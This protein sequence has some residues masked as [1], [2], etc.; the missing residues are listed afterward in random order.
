MLIITASECEKNHVLSDISVIVSLLKVMISA[1]GNPS[2]QDFSMSQDDS[3]F[4]EIKI[5]VEELKLGMYVNRLDKSWGE[6]SFLFQGFLIENEKLL[7]Q[8]RK[9]CRHVYIDTDRQAD[10]S[11]ESLERKSFFSFENLLGKKDESGLIRVQRPQTN[12]LIDIIKHKVPVETI[13]PPK[14]LASFEQEMGNAKLAQIKVRTMLK[15]FNEK[16][17]HGST[18]DMVAAKYAISDCMYSLLRSPDALLLINRLKTKRYT[19]WQHGMN[20]SVLAMSLG[21]YLNID[22]DELITLGLCGMFHDVGELLISKKKLDEAG[23]KK[24][25]LRSHTLLGRDLLLKCMGQMADVA[26][27]VAYCHHEHLDGSGFPRGL[28]AGQISMY[29]QIIGMVDVY[30]TLITDSAD[31]KGMTHYEAMTLLLRQANHSFDET[32]VNAFNK[33]I[34]TYP[35]GAVVEMNT[36][37]LAVVV[38]ENEAQRLRPK[39]MLLTDADKQKCN[40]KVV[41][42][43]ETK[44]SADGKL[45]AIKAIVR[46]DDYGV[47]L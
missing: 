29:A 15:D 6:S 4:N 40:K 46:A 36:G 31:K 42:L 32:L 25:L 16:I 21:R 18:V 44:T 17:R 10:T 2:Q 9:E 33:C 11:A 19:T 30:D 45:Y 13:V 41:D 28:K 23:D 43:L 37:E 34:G 8:L 3:G 12:Q 1:Y 24:E 27:D 38:E 39:I 47:K 5:P 22:D 7:K 14:K 26:A 20:V 35:V